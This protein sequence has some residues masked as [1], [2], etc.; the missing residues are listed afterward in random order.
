VDFG[1]NSEARATTPSICPGT[2]PCAA[3]WAQWGCWCVHRHGTAIAA[4][5]CVAFVPLPHSVEAARLS[6][7][8]NNT[9]VLC[10]GGRIPGGKR[11]LR[12]VDTWLSTGFAGGRMVAASPRSRP[13]KPPQP[14]TF[15]SRVSTTSGRKG[16]P[17]SIWPRTPPLLHLL[18]VRVRASATTSLAQRPQ[19]HG[20]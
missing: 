9:N 14:S 4:E 11:C 7:F 5:R 15:S 19:R 3:M 13:W 17:A 6:R 8:D 18:A 2:T 12:D 1:T 16:I 10:L 20:R